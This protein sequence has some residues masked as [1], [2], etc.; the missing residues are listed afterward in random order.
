MYGCR[1]VGR[2]FGIRD[3]EIIPRR[4]TD[5]TD[6]SSSPIVHQDK[7]EAII[8]QETFDQVQARL[9]V[10][11]RNTAPK[12]ARQYLLSGLCVCGDC[13]SRMQGTRP[14]APGYCCHLY[15][16]GGGS[17]CWH[18][19]ISEAPLVE[20]IVR[21]I[22][23]RYLSEAALARLRKA[24]EAE[25]ARDEPKPRD[26]ARLR[27]EIEVLDRKIDNAETAVLDA[28]VNSRS[29]LYH[30]L[31][32]MNTERDRLKA[33]LAALASRETARGT[34]DGSEIDQAIEALQ[35][36]REA[37]AEAEPDETK[38]LL[39]AV[40]SK[41]VLH[42]NHGETKTGRKTSKF[43]H[44]FIH[45]KPD[46]GGGWSFGSDDPQLSHLNNTGYTVLRSIPVFV[47]GTCTPQVH[48]HV[49]RTE[50]PSRRPGV[51]EMEGQLAAVG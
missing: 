22:R 40:V 35:R 44:G 24:L 30:K 20:C 9:T 28:P 1:T 21:K 3:G 25:Q 2:Y 23:E 13:N 50:H 32:T 34:N 14:A 51:W 31:E 43:S 45:V 42:F 39:A 36:L 17:A 8:D 33:E 48:A 4:K 12:T 16:T 49:G 47:Q 29:G 6:R 15:H 46:A 19:T 38:T 11:K 37:F 7:F 10:R 5:G 26:E 41:I 18:N 27:R